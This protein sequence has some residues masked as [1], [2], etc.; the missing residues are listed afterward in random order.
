MWLT[1]LLQVLSESKSGLHE[2]VGPLVLL[3]CQVLWIAARNFTQLA[4]A[5]MLLLCPSV[6]WNTLG[7]LCTA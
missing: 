1:Y 4:V 3:G 2:L 7:M 5:F 6:Q